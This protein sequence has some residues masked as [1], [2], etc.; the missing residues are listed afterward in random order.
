MSSIT[1]N[2]YQS[3]INKVSQEAVFSKIRLRFRLINFGSC[4]ESYSLSNRL[5]TAIKHKMFMLFCRRKPLFDMNIL[6]EILT[7]LT[8]ILSS[9]DL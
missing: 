1:L 3:T 5:S 2:Y 7:N 6:G 8:F 9:Q 4:T